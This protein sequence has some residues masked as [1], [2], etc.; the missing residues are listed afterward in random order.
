MFAKTNIFFGLLFVYVLL[1]IYFFANGYLLGDA[2]FWIGTGLIPFVLLSSKSKKRTL[3]FLPAALL[4]FVACFF[5][6]AQSIR[7]LFLLFSI[8]FLIESFKGK[9]NASLFWIL[10]IISPLFRYLSEIF[11]F[12]IR[13]KLSSW[14]GIFL[15]T[16][17]F[18]V[19]VSGNI[20]QVNGSD[21]SVDP[22]CMGLQMV[23]FSF[24]AGIFL[25]TNSE[26][27]TNRKLPFLLFV[28]IMMTA[29][30]L[31]ILSN[32]MRILALV[33]FAIPPQNPMHDV[34][35]ILSLLLYVWLP[36]S[37]LI[38]YLYRNH[39][40]EIEPKTDIP[41]KIQPFVLWINIIILIACVAFMLNK[42]NTNVIS[43]NTE[44]PLNEKY[45]ITNL[46]NGITQFRSKEALVYSKG[47]PSFYSTEHSP[48]TCWKGSG[49][50]FTSIKEDAVSGKLIYFGTLQKGKDKLCTAWWFSNGKHITISQLDWRWKVFRGQPGFQLIN[51]TASNKDQLNTAIK[52][53]L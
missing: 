33:I 46:G 48:Y 30:A 21:F 24:L 44:K 18:P 25:I 7:Y 14:T 3:R 12:P 11:T 38:S 29:F 37:F 39:A 10:L 50:A 31:N 9:L 52:E 43:G 45:L 16:A 2:T 19:Q 32:L 28:L 6:K 23:G 51:V 26:R 40:N 41:L 15:E 47:I 34:V 36:L 4:L 49:Y 27:L 17:G 1:F 8:V 5:I 22:A 53:W 13:L 42:T 20:I 35:G